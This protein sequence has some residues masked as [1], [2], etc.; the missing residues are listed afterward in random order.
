MLGKNVLD[1]LNPVCIE[2]LDPPSWPAFR[3]AC[4]HKGMACIYTCVNKILY[5]FH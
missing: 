1:F 5:T 3:S 2:S 4:E